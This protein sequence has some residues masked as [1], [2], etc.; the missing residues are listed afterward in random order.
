M[1]LEIEITLT[2]ENEDVEADKIKTI[3]Q[4]REDKKLLEK[5]EKYGMFDEKGEWQQ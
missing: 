1:G 2:I 4:Q 5:I 3:R